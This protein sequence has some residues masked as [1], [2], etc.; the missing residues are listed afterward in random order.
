MSPLHVLVGSFPGAERFAVWIE[1]RLRNH[2]DPDKVSRFAPS[3]AHQPGSH[4]IFALGPQWQSY[5]LQAPEVLRAAVGVASEGE[6][7]MILALMPEAPPPAPEH[8]PREMG[9]LAQ[10]PTVALEQH[11]GRNEYLE[12][13]LAIVDNLVQMMQ[14]QLQRKDCLDAQLLTQIE[15]AL[16][17]LTWVRDLVG[18]Y[19]QEIP[20]ILELVAVITGDGPLQQVWERLHAVS[21][22][23][24]EIQTIRYAADILNQRDGCLSAQEHAAIVAEVERFDEW[25]MGLRGRPAPTVPPPTPQAPPAPTEE[26]R[27]P[28]IALPALLAIVIGLALLVGVIYLA[29]RDEDEEPEVILKV[30]TAT[31][32]VA[33][34][35]T[36]TPVPAPATYHFCATDNVPVFRQD[37]LFLAV[38]YPWINDVLAPRQLMRPALSD[39]TLAQFDPRQADARFCQDPERTACDEYVQ[40]VYVSG[41]T[42]EVAEL[43]TGL[44][45][46][47][48]AN[49]FI[50]MEV[51]PVA[52]RGALERRVAN[53]TPTGFFYVSTDPCL[54]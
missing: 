49:V 46:D 9:I 52:S 27:R 53:E 2:F 8:L 18:A 31:H 17:G 26:R 28:Q 33:P 44:V 12:L 23:Q 38:N 3:A 13:G 30:A 32:T 45:A 15:D 50:E 37:A 6:A 39:G 4:I 29:L 43:I 41:A 5:L 25:Y 22:I 14:A 21:A 42:D 11:A 54:E 47:I 1:E 7:K 34:V 19:A 48:L 24:G 10:F 51:V 35:P 40:F 20:G 16:K 36:A